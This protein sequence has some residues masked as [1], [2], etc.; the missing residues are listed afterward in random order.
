MREHRGTNGLMLLKDRKRRPENS[1]FWA[2]EE[3]ERLIEAM[4]MHGKRWNAVK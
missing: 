1:S 2:D 4:E 3:L